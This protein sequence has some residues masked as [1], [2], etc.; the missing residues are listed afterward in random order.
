MSSKSVLVIGAGAIGAFYASRLAHA[1]QVSCICRSNFAVVS[2]HGFKMRTQAFGDYD[3]HPAYTFSSPTD[4]EKS[5]IKWDYIIVAMKALP[6]ISD[7]T[8]LITKLVHPGHSSIV[9]LQNGVGIE[10][11]YRRAFPLNPILSA[12]T[13]A[14]CAQT[15]PGTI[16]QKHWNTISIGPY[17]GFDDLN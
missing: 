10:T 7:D 5:G 13:L 3:F 8:K 15:Q 14:S 11:P 2:K 4:C 16:V 17:S 1:A 12:V 9:L 6:D